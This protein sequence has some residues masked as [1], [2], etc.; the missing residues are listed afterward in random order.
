M[1]AVG[2]GVPT[3]SARAARARVAL[4]R[5]RRAGADDPSHL[6]ELHQ[7]QDPPRPRLHPSPQDRRRDPRPLLHRAPQARRSQGS[8]AGCHDRPTGPLHHPR[9]PRPGRQ[10]GMDPNPAEQATIPRYTHQ[11]VAP[12]TPR[13]VERFLTAAWERDPDLGTLLWVAMVTGARRGELCALRWTHVRPTPDSSSSPAASPTA[14]GKRWT[15][16]PRP[17]KPAASPS[18][19]PPPKSSPSTGGTARNG[20][21]HAASRCSQTAMSSPPPRPATNP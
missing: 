4:A 13:E 14:T 9:R 2:G 3:A 17:T 12:P 11:E 10:M 7:E 6:P 8:T 18:T 19:K 20:R 15:R 16:T 1:T 21:P 5:D